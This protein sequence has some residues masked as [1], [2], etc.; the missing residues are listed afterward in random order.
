MEHCR[1]GPDSRRRTVNGEYVVTHEFPSLAVLRGSF[2]LVT[3]RGAARFRNV[4]FLARHDG[5]TGLLNR[6]EFMSLLADC[7]AQPRHQGCTLYYIDLDG[8]KDINDRLGHG[9]G[10]QG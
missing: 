8:F 5:M 1:T 3:G 9:V 7:A 2:G 10:D 4:R 6:S